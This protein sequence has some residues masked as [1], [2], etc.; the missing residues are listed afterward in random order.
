MMKIEKLTKDSGATV[1]VIYDVP[2]DAGRV[3]IMIHGFE[4]SKEC[5]TGQMLFR[6][7]LP[8]GIGVVAYDQPGH[9]SEEAREELLTLDN[10]K[11]SLRRVE[12]F[13]TS[14][15]P[16]AEIMYFGSSFG[17]YLTGLYVSSESHRG[18]KFFMRSAAVNMPELFLGN[19]DPEALKLLETQ[20]YVE[21]DLGTGQI[22][23]VPL[24]MFEDF[25]ENNLFEKFDRNQVEAVMVHG[26]KDT[27]IDPAKARAFAAKFDIPITLIPGENHSICLNPESPDIVGDMAIEFF[28]G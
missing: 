11:S 12:D 10:C 6:R 7:M 23:K 2:D 14:M 8:E 24:Q 9:G 16:D 17:A 1:P 27:V 18:R 3:V 19:P 22:V 21:P 28:G 13:V 4:S 15:W 20:G 5:A 26:E 25:R